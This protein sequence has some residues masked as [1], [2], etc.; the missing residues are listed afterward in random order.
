MTDVTSAS[1]GDRR[2]AELD[3]DSVIAALQARERFLTNILGGLESFF[4]VDSRWRCT[5]ANESGGDLTRE[6]AQALLGADLRDYLPA[7][8]RDEVCAQLDVA[9]TERVSI[10]VGCGRS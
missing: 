10:T 2:A 5:F 6:S 7:E 9:M 3:R 1:A 4:T 8:L